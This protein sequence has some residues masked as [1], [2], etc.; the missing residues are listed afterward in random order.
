MTVISRR[1]ALALVGAGSL[2]AACATGKAGEE[3]ASFQAA[4]IS[5][6][7]RHGVASGDPDTTSLII[8]TRISTDL[9]ELDVTGASQKTL[10]SH[11]WP[12]PAR[13]G[14]ALPLTGP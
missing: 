12:R 13:S 1:D 11:N 14:Q 9:Q 6:R 2:A 5:E 8:W 7:F 3:A 4:A 10:T